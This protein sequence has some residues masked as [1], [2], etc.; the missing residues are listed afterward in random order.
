MREEFGIPI[1][2]NIKTQRY[3]YE[4]EGIMY[5][6][7]I[8]TDILATE[9]LRKIN[10]RIFIEKNYNYFCQSQLVGLLPTIFELRF[11]ARY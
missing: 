8:S 6:G 4:R 2:Y 5:F 9:S 11:L 10:G 1:I 3:E 7:F